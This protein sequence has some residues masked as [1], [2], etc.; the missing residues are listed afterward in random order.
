MAFMSTNFTSADLEKLEKAIASGARKVV[1]DGMGSV[2]YHSI[3]EM[4]QARALIRQ[5]LGISKSSG[6]RYAA[7]SSG[8]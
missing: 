4:M 3:D 5:E 8:L 2:E 6:R 1:Y 7:F